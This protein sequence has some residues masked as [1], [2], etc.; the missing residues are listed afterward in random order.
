VAGKASSRATSRESL[1][2]TVRLGC[3]DPG[4]EYATKLATVDT[5]SFMPSEESI[6][7]QTPT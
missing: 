2:K 7:V 5:I 3:V 4:G 1:S 6:G